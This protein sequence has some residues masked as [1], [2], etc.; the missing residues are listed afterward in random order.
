MSVEESRLRA[1]IQAYRRLLFEARPLEWVRT[2][3]EAAARA[4]EGQAVLRLNQSRNVDYQQAKSL[5]P[6]LER[7]PLS[8]VPGLGGL[9][10]AGIAGFALFSYFVYVLLFR[11]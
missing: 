6:E 5:A 4:W 11:S 2:Q 9:L 7:A 8:S 1:E 10:L 3:D